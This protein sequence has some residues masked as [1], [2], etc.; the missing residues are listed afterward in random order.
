MP[1]TTTPQE[2]ARRWL[3]CGVAD[4]GDLDKLARASLELV[5]DSAEVTPA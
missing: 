5:R 2:I 3:T 4:D 1:D